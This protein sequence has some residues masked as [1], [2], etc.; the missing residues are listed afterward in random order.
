MLDRSN[1]KLFIRPVDQY[2][3]NQGHL[4]SSQALSGCPTKGGG[5]WIGDLG[6]GA[7]QAA[8]FDS[9]AEGGG[10]PTELA[11]VTKHA[12]LVT[13]S[14]AKG[15]A[16]KTA[17]VR[18]IAVIAAHAG[19]RVAVIDLDLQRT[20]T[21]WHQ[22]RPKAAPTIECR[23]IPLKGG[24]KAIRAVVQS[25]RFDLVVVD[26][27]P[28][29]EDHAADIRALAKFSD[30]VLV[31][32][33]PQAADIESNVE[34]ARV[35]RRDGVHYAF[36]LARTFRNRTAFASSKQTLLQAGPLCPVDVR[37]AASV[38]R[39][40]QQGL[41]NFEIR[42]DVVG[43]DFLGVWSYAARELALVGEED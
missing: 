23:P 40:H 35:L 36:L 10:A 38:D 43:Q 37:E 20:L 4:W 17:T 26:T 18:N 7:L 14:A 9:A 19:L 30:L 8:P 1:M 2:V 5:D 15:G 34:W 22:R 31:P 42:G 32:S 27:P 6:M 25:G 3:E 41:G 11:A 16:T 28:G 12:K 39:S 24:A 21:K 33:Q 13:V 29:L